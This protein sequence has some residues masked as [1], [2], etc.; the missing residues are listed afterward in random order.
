MR[1]VPSAFTD[2]I[3]QMCWRISPERSARARVCCGLWR[4][5]T[6]SSSSVACTQRPVPRDRTNTSARRAWAWSHRLAFCLMLSPRIDSNYSPRTAWGLVDCSFLSI[7][8]V[9]GNVYQASALF[10]A[11]ENA[12]RSRIP[13]FFAGM[14]SDSLCG[15][16]LSPILG[17]DMCWESCHD[18]YLAVIKVEGCFA[19]LLPFS[20]NLNW[21]HNA[22]QLPRASEADWRRCWGAHFGCLQPPHDISSRC[23]STP[24]LR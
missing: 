6:T 1:D 16:P 24:R 22:Q 3:V 2:M 20:L 13:A 10:F 21:L 23:A 19:A 5:K 8:R 12:E 17:L 9:C 11:V 4:G 7:E 15:R 14:D 18:R